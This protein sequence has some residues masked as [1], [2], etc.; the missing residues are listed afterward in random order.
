MKVSRGGALIRVASF[1]SIG[2]FTIVSF[3]N[4]SQQSFVASAQEVAALKSNPFDVNAN[5]A[6]VMGADGYPSENL[7]VATADQAAANF[8]VDCSAAGI[9][10]RERAEAL[11]AAAADPTHMTIP[12]QFATSFGTKEDALAFWAHSR[13]ILS[14][15]NPGESYIPVGGAVDSAYREDGK[16]YSAY[17][18]V[19]NGV[20]PSGAFDDYRFGKRCFFDTVKVKSNGDGSPNFVQIPHVVNGQESIYPFITEPEDG[21]GLR[22]KIKYMWYGWCDPNAAGSENCAQK[23]VAA[24]GGGTYRYGNDVYPNRL[25]GKLPHTEMN[26]ITHVGEP[27]IVKLYVADLRDNQIRRSQLANPIIKIPTELARGAEVA[28]DPKQ[29]LDLKTMFRNRDQIVV[30]LSSDYKSN[31]GLTFAGMKGVPQ[32]LSN[33]LLAGADGTDLASQYTPIVLDLGEAG[34]LTS[35]RFGGTFFNLSGA[36][37][38]NLTDD[39]ALD[40]P[41]QTAWLGGLLRDVSGVTPIGFRRKT[42]SSVVAGPFAHDFRRVADDAF[43]VMTDQDGQVR[44]GRNLFGNATVV[45]GVTYSNGFLALQALAG[46]DCKSSDPKLQY[47]G[48]WDQD[49]YSAKI[50]V[51]VD[52]NRNGAVDSGEILALKDA[53]VVAL[54]TCNVVNQEDRDAFGNGT[55]LRSAFLFQQGEDITGDE[56]EILKRLATGVSSK[57]QSVSF[58]LAI[59]LIFQVNT[60]NNFFSSEHVIVPGASTVLARRAGPV[61]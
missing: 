13:A 44:S 26:D 3:Q 31:S 49:L 9:A 37:D 45:N 16:Y 29:F 55:S 39:S 42:A 34:V 58:R 12:V 15:S 25:F 11:A 1:L 10:D 8:V 61:R 6:G 2:S 36:F 46:K 33:I 20:S 51:W 48:P 22:H 18:V 27:Q 19:D 47:L 24:Y 4:C 54:N 41:H 28:M 53:G 60:A 50:K 32:L 38:P 7:R 59:D 14:E 57:G 56:S 40:Q 43:L 30:N 52:A 35:S 23:G 17:Y 21:S 5:V